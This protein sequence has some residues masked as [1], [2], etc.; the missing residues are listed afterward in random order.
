MER[1]R[2]WAMPVGVGGV[3]LLSWAAGLTE[4]V[5]P[6]VLSAWLD[7]AGP[8]GVL[9]FVALFVVANLAGIPGVVFVFAALLAYGPVLGGVVSMLGSTTAAVVN[10]TVL[11][12]M[13]G[14]SMEGGPAWIE[15][16]MGWA[17]AR[18]VRATF[19]LRALTVVA[20]PA[21]VALALSPVRCRDH[22]LGSALGLLVPVT[23]YAVGFGAVAR[24]L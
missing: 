17:E 20:P 1:W 18:P 3:L 15:R 19:V 21:N 14:G 10:V 5:S 23:F 8:W 9:A 24:A 2:T 12:W 4:H 7:A 11:R 16:V 6:E 13:G 22:A